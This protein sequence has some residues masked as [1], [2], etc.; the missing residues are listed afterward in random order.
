MSRTLVGFA[1]AANI[2]LF[3]TATGHHGAFD[4]DPDTIEARPIATVRR[5]LRK[6]K[7]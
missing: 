3:D 1:V 5:C 4:Y 7:A 6:R 2:G